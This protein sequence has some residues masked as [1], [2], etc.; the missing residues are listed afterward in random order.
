MQTNICVLIFAIWVNFYSSFHLYL[1]HHFDLLGT[2]PH[3]IKFIVVE[4]G[5]GDR[6]QVLDKANCI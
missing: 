5:T 1:Q 3:H 6:V 2:A 4:K